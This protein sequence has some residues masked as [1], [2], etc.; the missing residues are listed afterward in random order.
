MHHTALHTTLRSFRR[1]DRRMSRRAAA[2]LVGALAGA[3]AGTVGCGNT[4]D[5]APSAAGGTLVIATAGDA[6][7]LI[8]PLVTT[9]QGAQVTAQLFDRLAEPDSTLDTEGDAHFRP[10][11]AQRWT[12]ARDSLSLVFTLDPRARW[13]DGRPVTARDVAFSYALTV[14]SLTGSPAAPLLTSIDSVTAR[15]SLTAVVWFARRDPRQFY[16]ATYNL[17]VLPAHL[18]AAVP[19]RELAASAFARQPVGSGRFRFVSWTPGQQITLVADTANYRGRPKLDRLVWAISA[20]PGAATRR[21]VTGEADVWEQLRGDGLAQ[22][23][24]TPAVR[25]VTY[26]SM[27]VGYLAFN[28]RGAS[29]APH[30]LF[31]DRVLRRALAGA[32][33]RAA[34]VRNVFDTLALATAWPQPSAVSVAPGVPVGPA[35]DVVIASAALDALGWR[36]AN[37]DGIRER[38]GRPLRMRLIVPTT[39][40]VRQRLAVLVQA[41]LARVGVAVTVDALDPAAFG[42]AVQRGDYDAM[43]NAWHT[44]P[45]PTA[46]LQQWGEPGAAGRG[47]ANITG[48]RSALFDARV[49]SAAATRGVAAE[50]LWARAY[51]TLADDV[52]ALW[53]YEPRHVAGIHRRVRPT[54]LRAD[55]WW[56]N[57]A[58]WEIPAGER[59]ARDRIGLRVA[60]R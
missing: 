44:D 38:G 7:L 5:A 16:D 4:P 24:R 13:H 2:I 58:D 11:L 41:Q 42:R 52:P 12:W 33:D 51:T 8:P 22:A 20:D 48:Y 6:D 54:G 31:G 1:R 36:D 25:T 46:I 9:I 14:D 27:D 18:L 29:G 35:Y 10:R 53:L 47:S 57:L 23:A 30:P 37:G 26:R 28:L 43:L 56:A 19:R 40:Q 21:L 59:I 50:S 15:D 3:L 39:S 32:I 17:W 60:V 55:A 34:I 49:D 45:S